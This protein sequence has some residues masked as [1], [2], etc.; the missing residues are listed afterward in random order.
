MKNEQNGRTI[1][2]AEHIQADARVEEVARMLSG[3]SSTQA[4]LEHARQLLASASK[5]R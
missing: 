4:S 3:D 1:T 5:I 2:S